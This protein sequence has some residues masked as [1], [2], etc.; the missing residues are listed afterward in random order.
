MF[1]PAVVDVIAYR[2]S[3]FRGQFTLSTAG[4]G[5]SAQNLTDYEIKMQVRQRPGDPVLAEAS[6]DGPSADGSIITI[7]SPTTGVFEVF[8]SNLDLQDVS[9]PP[10]AQAGDA[11][12]LQ[13]DILFTN[14]SNNDTLALIKG[15]FSIFPGITIK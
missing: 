1:E 6:T 4:S 3:V 8:L 12:A 2:N 14:P 11:I 7:I 10:S 15:K 9:V 5:G 13:Y